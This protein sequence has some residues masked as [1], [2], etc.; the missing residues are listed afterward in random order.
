MQ[1]R[2]GGRPFEPYVQTYRL[3]CLTA[4]QNSLVEASISSGSAGQLSHLPARSA[5]STC[6]WHCS[7]LN[8][9]SRKKL[10]CKNAAITDLLKAT[11]NCCIYFAPCVNYKTLFWGFCSVSTVFL[12]EYPIIS[13]PLS[14]MYRILFSTSTDINSA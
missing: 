8:V 10:I 4:P 13:S 3:L 6:H 11:C 2:S 14:L 7:A 9:K 5:F 1:K 12:S